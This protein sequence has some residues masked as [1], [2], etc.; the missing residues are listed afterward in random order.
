MLVVS[1][2]CGASQFS[3][4]CGQH[5]GQQ[6]SVCLS[7]CLYVHSYLYVCLYICLCV[8]LSVCVCVSVCMSVCVSVHLSLC[9]SEERGESRTTARCVL[10]IT[11]KLLELTERSGSDCIVITKIFFDFIT[12]RFGLRPS[13]KCTVH[14]VYIPTVSMMQYTCIVQYTHDAIYMYCTLHT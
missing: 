5:P 13:S 11:T 8:C 9:V 4:L 3:V 1:F 7:I 14:R 12:Q 10:A 6:L 2:M